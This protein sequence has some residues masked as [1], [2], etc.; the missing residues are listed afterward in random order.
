MSSATGAGRV[1]NGPLG[2]VGGAP[3]FEP[4]TS[5]SQSLCER[6]SEASR[7]RFFRRSL[8]RPDQKRTLH[9][10]SVALCRTK[11][12]AASRTRPDEVTQLRL[13]YRRN[14]ALPAARCRVARVTVGESAKRAVR[15]H[16]TT[17]V[18]SGRFLAKVLDSRP[19][20][21][22]PMF[23]G[24]RR[25]PPHIFHASQSGACCMR[26]C[27]TRPV[28]TTS[29]TR[30]AGPSSS[31]SDLVGASISL[32]ISTF[33]RSTAYSFRRET[34]FGFVLWTR[35][36]RWMWPTCWRRSSRACGGAPVPHQYSSARESAKLRTVLASANDRSS[37]LEIP[38]KRPH[39]R[40]PCSMLSSSSSHSAL[41]RS[42]P[43]VSAEP[44]S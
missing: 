5:C 27:V 37:P 43:C 25:H 26:W 13:T 10:E 11:S 1:R 38:V 12:A 34:I 35:L 21:A 18:P 9:P 2:K 42:E 4:R 8:I 17:S 23:S 44:T 20:R 33:W 14:H 19:A 31:C 30:E 3:G 16:S 24:W 22:L 7:P 6:R 41:V 32:F 39:T 36:T 15:R 28:R 40:P 29:W